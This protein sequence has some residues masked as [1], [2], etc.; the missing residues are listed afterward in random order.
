VNRHRWTEAR[1][2]KS[3]GDQWSLTR[4]RDDTEST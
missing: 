1:G 4:T 2:Q 3:E